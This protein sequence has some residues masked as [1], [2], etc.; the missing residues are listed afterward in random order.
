MSDL[1]GRVGTLATILLGLFLPWISQA[2]DVAASIERGRAFLQSR[3]Q[4]AGGRGETALAALA[5]S[6]SGSKMDDPEFAA[7]VDNLARTVD[8]SGYKPSSS[9][10]LDNYE[11]AV[12]IM[13]LVSADRERYQPQI[14]ALGRYLLS[15]QRAG[16]PWDYG[17]GSAGDTSQSQYALLGLWEAAAAGLDVPGDAWDRALHW[18][19]TRQDLAGGF[20]YHPATPPGD[21]RIQQ[22]MVQHSTTAG[23]VF[24]MVVCRSNLSLGNA[25]TS[26][27]SDTS[28]LALLIPVEPEQ[29]KVSRPIYKP[30]V[31]KSAA[32]EAVKLGTQWLNQH[33]TVDKPVG[34]LLYYLYGVERLGTILNQTSFGSTDWYKQGSAFLI[35]RQADNGSWSS[36]YDPVVDTS[37]AILFLSRSTQKTLEKIRIVRLGEA[38]MTGGKGLP[39]ADG[40]PPEYLTRQKARYRAALATSVDEILSKLAD[41]DVDEWDQGAAASIENA[42]PKEIIEK[43]GKNH[44]GLRRM[45]KHPSPAVREAGLW[46]LARLRD[47]RFAP[48]LIN[49]LSDPDPEVYLAAR[50]GLLFLSRK[51]DAV[52]LP[53]TPPPQP[54]LDAAIKS[55]RDWYDG[56]HVVVEPDQQFDD[57]R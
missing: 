42:N 36:N 40:T 11:T 5:L 24:S 41:L 57:G 22:A 46:G 29:E 15:R 12:M 34:P 38:T 13:A 23:G 16:G 53:D 20:A 54:V 30:K 44:A 32:D 52:P 4:T 21:A 3:I 7:V 37:F 51:L 35:S 47:F 17:S 10:G 19:I 27:R 49:G 33:F 56:L 6:K 9:L 26:A 28:E 18:H 2:Q 31:T 39:T 48:I 55:W 43:L 14:L 50:D 8:V 25:A 1:F 45:A